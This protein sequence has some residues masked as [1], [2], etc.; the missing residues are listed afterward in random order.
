MARSEPHTTSAHIFNLWRRVL[1]SCETGPGGG[2]IDIYE[3]N[4]QIPLYQVVYSVAFLT[5]VVSPVYLHC[6]PSSE[7]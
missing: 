7:V 1:C 2:Q 6:C 3:T 5:H 4:N